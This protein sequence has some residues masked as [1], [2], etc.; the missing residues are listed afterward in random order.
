LAAEVFYT[1]A[2]EELVEARRAIAA[3]SFKVCAARIPASHHSTIPQSMGFPRFTSSQNRI[4]GLRTSPHGSLTDARALLLR[5][6]AA[7]ERLQRLKRRR[8][9]FVGEDGDITPEAKPYNDDTSAK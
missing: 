6:Q 5:T 9:A 3:F 4:K 2:L 1:V 7:P 8:E